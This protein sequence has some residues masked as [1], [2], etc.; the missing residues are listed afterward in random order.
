MIVVVV[1]VLAGL[2]VL[3]AVVVLAMGKGGELAATHPDHPPLP[4]HQLTGTDAALLRLPRGIWGYQVGATDEAMR[5]LAY[6]LAER[7]TRMAALEQQ[8]A[9]LYNRLGIPSE[10]PAEH[11]SFTK[12]P[13][14]ENEL[15]PLPSFAPPLEP[16]DDPPADSLPSHT[17][18][19][20][21]E[22]P[23]T[24][25]PLDD[26]PPAGGEPST[27]WLPDHDEP[28]ATPQPPEARPPVVAPLEDEPLTDG[29][30]PVAA[31]PDDEP[32]ADAPTLADD[33]PPAAPLSLGDEPSA[34]EQAPEVGPPSSD[35]E[36]PVGGRPPIVGPLDD[37][38]PPFLV[39]PSASAEP[40]AR[41]QVPE[42][43][44]ASGHDEPVAGGEPPSFTA[45]PDGG[46]V[47]SERDE[48]GASVWAKAEAAFPGERPVNREEPSF[49][50]DEIFEAELFDDHESNAAV[51]RR[52]ERS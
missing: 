10:I 1:L 11:L 35:A 13:T 26:E 43:G 38:E 14:T 49:E 9:D 21:A 41:E 15:P 4:G 7:E 50:E 18:P 12:P 39:E 22:E 19:P 28:S 51:V 27:A 17:A 44:P 45:P 5:R 47:V 34:T 30:P 23:P 24:V 2:A 31:L 32:L 25:A 46:G 48:G 6:S 52:D 29:K 42:G 40:S 3:G 8:L 16:D 33:E 20:A 37:D 36:P